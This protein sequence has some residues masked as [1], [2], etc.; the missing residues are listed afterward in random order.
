MPDSAELARELFS[1]SGYTPSPTDELASTVAAALGKL[2]ADSQR[3]R[4]VA[5]AGAADP[6][7]PAF[8]VVCNDGSAF[9]TIIDGS[10]PSWIPLPAVP[11]CSLEESP[12]AE[13]T[14]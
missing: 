2:A 5:I 7:G 10:D 13:A 11:G 3:R 4:P 8:V 6:D 12:P 14:G 1:F 9:V